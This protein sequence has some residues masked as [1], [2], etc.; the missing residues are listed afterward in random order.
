MAQVTKKTIDDFLAVKRIAVIGMSRNAGDYSRMLM[1]EFSAAGYEIIPVNP[2]AEEI[3]G[4]RC[5]ARVENIAPVPARVIIILPPDKAE[6]AVIDC[7]EAGVKD[8]WLHSHI[9][10][11][12]QNSRAI[13]QAENHG[14]N[15]ISGFCP[16]MFLPQARFFHK[17]HGGIL[18]LMGAYPK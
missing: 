9:A 1:K 10:A 8:I 15:L 6:Q 13:Y 4:A 18:K 17:I 7:A 2:A 5:F 16:M 12:V 14:L 11:G 3:A